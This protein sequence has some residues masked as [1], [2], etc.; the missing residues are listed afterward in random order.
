MLPQPGTSL[1]NPSVAVAA[2][3]SGSCSLSRYSNVSPL[4][5]G[6]YR[7]AGYGDELLF[8]L[9][10]ARLVGRPQRP[11]GFPWDLRDS[12]NLPYLLEIPSWS[13]EWIREPLLALGCAPF[14]YAGCK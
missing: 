3:C 9:I 1:R 13:L 14:R 10:R 8:F 2:V 5:G 12:A 4:H 7:K 6:N 11:L